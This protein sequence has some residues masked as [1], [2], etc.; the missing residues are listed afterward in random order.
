MAQLHTHNMA[1]SKQQ[2]SAKISQTHK[3]NLPDDVTDCQQLAMLIANIQQLLL[4]CLC[5]RVS[6]TYNI[7]IVECSTSACPAQTS[8]KNC[9]NYNFNRDGE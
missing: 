2:C 9:L 8:R 3:T 1:I 6:V 5:H 4:D 7:N